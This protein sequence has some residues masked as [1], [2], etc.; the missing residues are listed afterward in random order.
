MDNKP[1]KKE[2]VDMDQL[3][4]EIAQRS[5][6]VEEISKVLGVTTDFL[7]AYMDNMV[8]SGQISR[9]QDGSYIG[10]LPPQK[11]KR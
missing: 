6:R 11:R 9:N 4:R 1:T 2:G 5:K 7:K 3:L 10:P 8:T